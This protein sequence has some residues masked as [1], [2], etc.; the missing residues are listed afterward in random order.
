MMNSAAEVVAH[1]GDEIR[2]RAQTGD[3]EARYLLILGEQW[4][5]GNYAEAIPLLEALAN[6]G[7]VGAAHHLANAYSRGQGV[8]QDLDKAAAWLRVA[9]NLGSEKAQRDLDNYAVF[10]SG[11]DCAP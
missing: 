10:Q 7:S 2:A 5:K 6:D 8:A 1:H 11:S 9:A 4:G 3:L